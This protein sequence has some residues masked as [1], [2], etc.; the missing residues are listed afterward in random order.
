MWEEIELQFED[1][2]DIDHFELS[3]REA[4]WPE[5]EWQEWSAP[6]PTR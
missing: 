4:E 6:I 3:M 2:L 5:E 1:D